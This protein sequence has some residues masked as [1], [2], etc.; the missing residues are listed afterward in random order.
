MRSSKELA[1][2][3][4]DQLE[5]WVAVGQKAFA[6]HQAKWYAD[7]CPHTMGDMRDRLEKRINQPKEIHEQLTR[8][9]R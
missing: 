2:A 3:V 7:T 6:W 8:R 5:K 9:H 1:D 4:L